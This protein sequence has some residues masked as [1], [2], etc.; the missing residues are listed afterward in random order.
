MVSISCGGNGTAGAD[1]LNIPVG[2]RPAALGGAYSALATDAYAPVWNPAALGMVQDKSLA[3]QYLSYLTAIQYE[4]L[5]YVH[6][7]D[8]SRA[9]GGSIQYL[10]SGSIAGTDESGMSTGDFSSHYAAYE[11]A[12]GQRLTDKLS[13]GAGGK[14][15]N[16][17]IS[18]VSA[19]ALA[20]D[21]GGYY[22]MDPRLTL[23]ATLTNVGEKLQFLNEGDSLPLAVHLASVYRFPYL[24]LAT[25]GVIPASGEFG[26]HFGLEWTPRSEIALRCGYRTDTL[27]GLSP[28][29]GFTL[30]LG[31]KVWQQEFSYAWLPLGDLGNTQYFSLVF[32]FGHPES[33]R[34]LIQFHAQAKRSPAH[35]NS[36]DAPENMILIE[37]LSGENDQFARK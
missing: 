33:Q 15:V 36:D 5:S 29:A 32:R 9:L 8:H 28:L 10:G 12:Y 3:T 19:N 2:A 26:F 14:W 6:P 18:D 11:L 17:K 20:M 24:T 23:A 22:Q 4:Y 13:L 7:L 16:A 27:S 1:F 35:D 30:G 37:L 21:F 34:S 25:E 31:I